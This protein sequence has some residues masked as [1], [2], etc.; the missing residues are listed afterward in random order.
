MVTSCNNLANVMNASL[1]PRQFT[2]Q[3]LA[4]ES[5][6]LPYTEVDPGKFS[7]ALFKWSQERLT[8]TRTLKA[9]GGCG[10]NISFDKKKRHPLQYSNW[11]TVWQVAVAINAM[12]IRTGQRGRWLSIG[13]G[14]CEWVEH[15]MDPALT[16]LFRQYR[17]H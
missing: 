16:L 5:I 3:Q 7:A 2:R 1:E 11:Y 8:P 12:C 9:G 14:I 10:L 13:H 6:L 17:Y 4:A 15:H